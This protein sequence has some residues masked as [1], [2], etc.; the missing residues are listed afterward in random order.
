YAL[1]WQSK[2][3]VTRVYQR[4]HLALL[5]ASS[6]E[7][8]SSR[9][10]AL[11]GLRRRRQ[12]LLLAPQPAA[13]AGRDEQLNGLNE[14]IDKLDGELLKLLP[15]AGRADDLTRSSPAELQKAL[16]PGAVLIDLLR[17]IDFD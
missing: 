1:I 10:Q 6:S 4:R 14:Q 16:P 9:W 12:D 13:S 3:A 5:A 17:Y 8:V 2:A 15:E 11:L 7:K